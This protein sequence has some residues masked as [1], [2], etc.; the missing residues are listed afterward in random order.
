MIDEKPPD[1]EEAGEPGDE[2]DDVKSLDPEV[3]SH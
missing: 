3:I 1:V 2:S